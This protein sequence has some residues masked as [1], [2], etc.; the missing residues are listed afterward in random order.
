M[1]AMFALAHNLGM[2]VVAEGVETDEQLRCL[3]ALD[4]DRLQGYLFSPPLP[5]ERTT[6]FLE[7]MSGAA[8]VEEVA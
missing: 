7:K 5:A 1:Q 4:C 2:T 8:V 6:E 3:K